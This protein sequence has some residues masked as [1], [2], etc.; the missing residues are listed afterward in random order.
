MKAYV[1]EKNKMSM[2]GYRAICT[3]S[4]CK[5]GRFGLN[6]EEKIRNFCSECGAGI[7]SA[8]PVCNTSIS[9]LWDE[10]KA[11]PP[12]VCGECGEILRRSKEADP[13]PTI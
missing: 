5:R 3:N 4:E 13:Q 9:E 6:P 12:N 2:N 8:C 1:L 11:D 7:I 10:W